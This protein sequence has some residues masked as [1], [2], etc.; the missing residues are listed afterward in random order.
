MKITPID[1]GA[2]MHDQQLLHCVKGVNRP[3]KE[4]IRCFVGGTF[5]CVHS[6]MFIPNNEAKNERGSYA[7]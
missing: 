3:M 6:R 5:G 2:T 1:T 7:N 4:I